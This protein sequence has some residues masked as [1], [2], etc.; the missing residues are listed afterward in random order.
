MDLEIARQRH[1]RNLGRLQA[2]GLATFLAV[3]MGMH[4]VDGAIVLTAMA[5]GTANG[6]LEHPGT[7]I[8]S[9]DEVMG[10]EERDGAVDGRFVHRVQ[11]IL[12]AL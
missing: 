8:N 6:I 2:E 1:Q 12:Q 10:Q 9:V 4:V 7:V 11:F 5:I 3:E